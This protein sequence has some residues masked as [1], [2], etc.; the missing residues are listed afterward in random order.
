[1]TALC[2]RAEHDNLTPRAHL[3]AH[4][5]WGCVN[6]RQMAAL[7]EGAIWEAVERMVAEEARRYPGPILGAIRR[8][9]AAYYASLV[10]ELT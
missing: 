3:E 10:K 5:Y 4:A 2:D 9:R 7:I 8:M 6:E 1:M